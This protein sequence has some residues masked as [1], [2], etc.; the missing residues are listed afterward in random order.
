MYG[1]S[2]SPHESDRI[3]TQLLVCLVSILSDLPPQLNSEDKIVSC[4]KAMMLRCLRR[5]FLM[6]N[7]R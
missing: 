7:W 1:I 5:Q 3:Y 2:I 6:K 4:T